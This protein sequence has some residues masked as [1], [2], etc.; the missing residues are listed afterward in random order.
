MFLSSVCKNKNFLYKCLGSFIQK[1]FFLWHKQQLLFKKIYKYPFFFFLSLFCTNISSI[2]PPHLITFNC[3]LSYLIPRRELPPPS[4]VEHFVFTHSRRRQIMEGGGC[5]SW[6]V[7]AGGWR[8]RV[9]M[10]RVA[11]LRVRGGW[12]ALIVLLRWQVLAA[13]SRRWRD[14]LRIIVQVTGVALGRCCCHPSAGGIVTVADIRAAGGRGR[15]K[16]PVAVRPVAAVGGEIDGNS[17]DME[18]GHAFQATQPWKS[19]WQ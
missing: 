8:W 12:A 17:V 9:E 18:K 1:F 13:R 10:V 11:P 7:C 15:C 6:G 3:T 14:G 5:P 2:P 16:M 19:E 4:P